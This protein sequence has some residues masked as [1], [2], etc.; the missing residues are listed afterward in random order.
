MCVEP[1]P[2]GIY[3][4]LEA[5]VKPR[6]PF[7]VGPRDEPALL[8]PLAVVPPPLSYKIFHCKFHFNVFD[9]HFIH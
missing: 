7:A 5:Y 2:T 4:S 6:L 3:F 9:C 8:F 1:E